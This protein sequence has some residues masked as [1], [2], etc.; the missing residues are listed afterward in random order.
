LFVDNYQVRSLKR[1]LFVVG[2][3]F[4]EPAEN[5][6]TWNPEEPVRIRMEKEG[7]AS[8][9]PESIMTAFRR[10]AENF[11][12]RAALGLTFLSCTDSKLAG[13]CLKR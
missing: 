9:T 4:L 6:V 13:A 5:L 3:D 10:I 1:S 11:P 8:E 7:P 2:P 12:N